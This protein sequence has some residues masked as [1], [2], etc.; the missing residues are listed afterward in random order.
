[1]CI[2]HFIWDFGYGLVHF[3]GLKGMSYLPEIFTPIH[4]T[5]KTRRDVILQLLLLNGDGILSNLILIFF[6][7][8]T[9]RGNTWRFQT[10]SHFTDQIQV[11]F[12]LGQKVKKAS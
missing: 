9:V 12:R 1:M 4:R 6:E 7:K 8:I 3:L 10:V 2:C 11:E 5:S